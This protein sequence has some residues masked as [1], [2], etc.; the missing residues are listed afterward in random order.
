MVGLT[1]HSLIAV[2]ARAFY[3]HQDTAT[4]VL[5]A[6][7]AVV[8][9]IAVAVALVGPARAWSAWRSRS[10]RG[11]GS[12]PSCSASC[13]GA[14]IPGLGLGAVVRVMAVTAVVAA[15]GAAAAFAVQE[16]LAGAW[17][18]DPFPAAGARPS[19]PGHAWPGVS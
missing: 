5:A 3:A 2:L 7:V 15:F 10:P 16:L 6:I 8:V 18:A 9:D 19:R 14:A 1:A 17:G 13:S 11:A 4:P 12:R